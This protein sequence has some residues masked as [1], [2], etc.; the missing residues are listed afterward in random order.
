MCP[1][2]G[3]Q[4]GIDFSFVR[5]STIDVEVS[6]TNISVPCVVDNYTNYDCTNLSIHSFLSK[7][8][9]LNNNLSL[10]LD[11]SLS[12]CLSLC[13]S[14]SFFLSFFLSPPS[15]SLSLSIYLYLS[16]SKTSCL[17]HTY[18]ASESIIYVSA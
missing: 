7:Y 9:L 12:V 18:V 17:I 1:R 14:L 10:S 8:P 2:A 11:L 5:L 6:G 15:L 4:F 13:L 16:L 3:K